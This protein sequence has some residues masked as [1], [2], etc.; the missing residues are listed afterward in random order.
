MEVLE[1]IEIE[2]FVTWMGDD[3]I[4]RTVVKPGIDI[5]I[6]EARKNSE[7]VNSLIVEGK[8][9]LIVDNRK[10]KSITKEARDHFSIKD[11]ETNVSAIAIIIG[12]S[13]SRMIANFYL[14]IN[15]PK[16]PVKLFN[17]EEKAVKWCKTFN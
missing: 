6:S 13:L 9:P 8:S 10:I 12:S 11:R 17:S 4:V 14:G 1:K 16:I 7:I 15:K 3:R 2:G 5:G